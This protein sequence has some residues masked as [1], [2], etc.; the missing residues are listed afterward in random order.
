MVLTA[1]P[2]RW[3][4]V[5]RTTNQHTKGEKTMSW[6]NLWDLLRGKEN[7]LCIAVRVLVIDSETKEKVML[8]VAVRMHTVKGRHSFAVWQSEGLWGTFTTPHE[9]WNNAVQ[10]DLARSV[11]DVY[12][13]DFSEIPF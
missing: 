2:E 5:G 9:F 13:A 8:P 4:T 6:L 10:K 11:R 12:A 7:T 1:K 3:Y